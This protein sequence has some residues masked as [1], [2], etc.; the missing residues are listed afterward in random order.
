M[1][2]AL[3]ND[4]FSRE[5]LLCIIT[6]RP[7][8][9]LVPAE[10][11]LAA[12]AV[13]VLEVRVVPAALVPVDQA[14]PVEQAVPKA[15]F[16]VFP[17]LVNARFPANA[18]PADDVPRRRCSADD[19]PACF[20]GL[21]PNCPLSRVFGRSA[22]FRGPAAEAPSFRGLWPERPEAGRGAR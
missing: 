1:L 14:V 11:A 17:P 12:M 2:G 18:V 5:I 20:R 10:E 9:V 4:P 15:P 8:S 16:F 19:V 3:L 6:V 21:R 7:R 13:P 22:Q